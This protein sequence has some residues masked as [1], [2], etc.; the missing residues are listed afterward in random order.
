M[1]LE[2]NVNISQF[3]SASFA[4]FQDRRC[5]K[6]E[7]LT[8]IEPAFQQLASL[9][10]VIEEDWFA[11]RDIVAKVP[12]QELEQ[13]EKTT[14]KTILQSL[15]LLK[16]NQKPEKL[17]AFLITRGASEELLFLVLDLCTEEEIK[18]FRDEDGY[19]LLD[20][21]VSTGYPKIAEGL[22][23][24]G[25]DMNAKFDGNGSTPL[26]Y[27]SQAGS[28]VQKEFI[29][30]FKAAGAKFDQD[31]RLGHT[32]VDLIVDAEDPE[33]WALLGWTVLHQAAAR[34]RLDD[35]MALIK[36]GA[37]PLT[38]D[39]R[40]YS[41][42]NVAL[43]RGNFLFLLELLKS[44]CLSKEH[45]KELLLNAKTHL[46]KL[47]I[48]KDSFLSPEEFIRSVLQTLLILEACGGD[49]LEDLSNGS[50]AMSCF[51]KQ[52]EHD[53]SMDFLNNP[54]E[55][56]LFAQ[57]R[58]HIIARQ[59]LSHAVGIEAYEGFLPG[60][61][62]DCETKLWLS[63]EKKVLSLPLL[64]KEKQIL[65]EIAK[66]HQ[67]IPTKEEV[68]KRVKTGK[69]T[70]IKSGYY[71]HAACVVICGNYLVIANGGQRPFVDE[72]NRET[73]FIAYR[74]DPK[75]IT[76]DLLVTLYDTNQRSEKE[77]LE[78][79]YRDLPKL[80][81]PKGKPMKDEV[82]RELESISPK[83]QKIGNCFYF[84]TKA[85]QRAVLGLIGAMEG[86]YKKDLKRCMKMAKAQSKHMSTYQ[87]AY[88]L[89]EFIKTMGLKRAIS[90]INAAIENLRKHMERH[91]ERSREFLLPFRALDQLFKDRRLHT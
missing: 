23:A 64:K 41:M 54:A 65:V 89:N 70:V 53:I 24:K 75:K 28:R 56:Q 36:A 52:R 58:K 40:G 77:F 6:Q 29:Q 1:S 13:G 72:E 47:E 9:G 83:E 44:G 10:E 87:R 69:L 73:T 76:E 31:D 74:I 33:L 91:G 82:C 78:F 48:I 81:S 14:F 19:N 3:P 50:S 4:L 22:V 55:S 67:K 30:I 62:R 66:T 46:E 21:A 2:S 71:Q 38:R 43:K 85:A 51:L 8:V 11:F 32:P 57:I 27:I 16:N 12:L 37:D 90:L 39:I 15:K 18:N 35:A 20:L 68:V 60:D 42:L 86:S 7:Y 25:A 34:N 61:G 5:S 80:L 17:L 84:A 79:A 26:H 88:F 63:F 45:Q 59:A 49:P